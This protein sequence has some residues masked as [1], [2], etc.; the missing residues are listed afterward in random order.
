LG[1]EYLN[2]GKMD[3]LESELANLRRSWGLN[4][5]QARFVRLVWGGFSPTEAYC[6]AYLG[7]ILPYD[8]PRYQSAASSASKLLKVHKVRKA[9]ESLET[10]EA[11][12]M[13]STRDV[14][15][16]ILAAIMMGE[17]EGTKPA[18]RIRAIIADNRMTGDDRPIRVEGELTFQAMLESLPQEI[19]PGAYAQPE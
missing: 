6:R 9:L 5:N 11:A 4:I 15:R 1:L 2:I 17:I 14:K 3:G 7:G 10:R 16:G 18:D 19:L 8:T 12:L 13:G